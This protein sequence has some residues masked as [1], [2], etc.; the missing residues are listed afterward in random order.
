MPLS[1]HIIRFLIVVFI[2]FVRVKIPVQKTRL[3][4]VYYTSHDD[5][6]FLLYTSWVCHQYNGGRKI[7]GNREKIALQ[8]ENFGKIM[9]GRGVAIF[10]I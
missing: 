8:L 5:E 4:A 2:L 10:H 6:L 1:R 9:R 3:A 7:Y